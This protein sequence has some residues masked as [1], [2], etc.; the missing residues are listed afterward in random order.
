MSDTVTVTFT[1]IVTIAVAVDVTVAIVTV[2]VTVD[3]TV[4]DDVTVALTVSVRGRKHGVSQE[5]QALARRL[6][7]WKHH[8]VHPK[9]AGSSPSQGT[10]LG[11]GSIPCTGGNRWMMR[12]SHINVFPSLSLSLSLS[13]ESVPHTLR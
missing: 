8:P 12:L 1:V 7:G 11:W 5:R 6:G 10:L 9:A 2:T 3:V 13:L 4:T